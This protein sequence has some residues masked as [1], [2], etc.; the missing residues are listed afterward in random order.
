MQRHKQLNRRRRGNAV[1][2]F[3][4]VGIPM[5][6][7][8]VSVMEMSRAMW[9]YHTIQYACKMTAAFASVH[10]ATCASP[11]SCLKNMSDVVATFKTYAIGVPMDKVALKLTSQSS[12][13][14]CSQVSTCS[15]N[16]SW[17]TTWPPTSDNAVGNA[18]QVRADY[19]F[20]T[21]LAMFWPGAGKPWSFGSSIGSGKFDLPGYSYQLIQF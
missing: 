8:W 1:V 16:A 15:S 19:T 10:G 13:V 2:E 9:Q 18:I 6:F 12:S 20:Y 4:V 17:S 3:T 21:A 5:L 14:S 11:N 7:L